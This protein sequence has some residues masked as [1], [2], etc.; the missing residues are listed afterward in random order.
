MDSKDSF[1]SGLKLGYPLGLGYF[2]LAFT[3]GVGASN[4]GLSLPTSLAM[5]LLSF[6]GVGQLTTMDLMSRNEKYIG[7]FLALLI[8][9]L[10][11]IVLSL[12]MSRKLDPKTPI[13][14]KLLI[15]MGNTDEIFAL[16]IRREGKIPPN[17]FLGVAFIPYL[18]WF[19][20]MLVG[21]VAGDILPKDVS[22]ALGMALYAMLI[23]AVVPVAKGSKPILYTVILS[24]VLSCVLKWMRVLFTGTSVV[25]RVFSALLSPSGVIIVGSLIT[26]IVMARRFP[27]K[28]EEEKE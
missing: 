17:Y 28:T 27:V 4:L 1:K 9:N 18:A 15:A 26:A 3:L 19:L 16:T 13:G 22:I 14:K 23:A 21:G 20:G 2:P 25:D 5:A 6:T 7:I 12:T 10:R 8:I 24:G 11:N